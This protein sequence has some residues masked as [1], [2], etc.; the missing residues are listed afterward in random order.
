MGQLHALWLVDIVLPHSHS[1]Q[2]LDKYVIMMLGS[3][4][5]ITSDKDEI[6]TVARRNYLL[7]TRCHRD[8][9]NFNVH[10]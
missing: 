9:Y 5:D 3:Y 4:V 8:I 2:I 1:S 7:S 10:L 6:T